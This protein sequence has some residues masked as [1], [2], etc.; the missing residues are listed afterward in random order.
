MA[1]FVD[2]LLIQ[3]FDGLWPPTL[4]DIVA[5]DLSS[6]NVKRMIVHEGLTA[7]RT[8]KEI[9]ESADAFSGISRKVVDIYYISYQAGVIPEISEDQYVRFD[10]V[11]HKILSVTDQGAQQ[12]TIE[13]VAERAR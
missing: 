8:Q 7:R 2:P 3:S 10:G 9:T 13:V 4:V 6:G 1:G 11:D 5:N 12:A